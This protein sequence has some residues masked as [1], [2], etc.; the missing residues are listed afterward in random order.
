MITQDNSTRWNST[1][2]SLHR[3]LKIKRR[4]RQFCDES[5][6][7]LKDD[8]LSD[9]DWSHL[10][11]I[12]DAL[13]PFHEATMRAQG[14]ADRG[15]HGSIWEVLPIIEALME[16]M[17]QGQQRYK[18][19]GRKVSPLEVAHQN[20]W[21]KLY[22]YYNLTDQSHSIYAAAILFHPSC[23]KAYFDEQWTG[24][25]MKIWKDKMI[26]T[27]RQTWEDNYKDKV[28]SDEDEEAK[29]RAKRPDFL[30]KYLKR[31]QPT[32]EGDAF[33]SYIASAPVA[34]N[35]S[36]ADLLAWWN[37]PTNPHKALQQQAFDL[38]S[39]PAMSAEVERVF[40]STKRLIPP[41]R[42]RLGDDTIELLQLLKHWWENKLI[43]PTTMPL[44]AI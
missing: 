30:D 36:D 23:R 28:T 19:I 31:A 27:V 33:Q 22:K 17:E 35:D 11:E 38:L 41:D 21:Q 15:H 44:T 25:K 39:I 7:A 26:A 20:A 40:S 1:Y 42:N 43:T 9:E 32:V 37:R 18:S 34:C 16:V 6:A 14:N 2:H 10:Q 4:L 3:G 24:D 8:C 5:R 29:R 13:Q 12:A